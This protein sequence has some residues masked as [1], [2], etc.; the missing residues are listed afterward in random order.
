ME[1]SSNNIIKYIK[2][3]YIKIKSFHFNKKINEDFLFLTYIQNIA[4][5]VE[6]CYNNS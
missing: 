4:N 1:T 2:Y 5:F 3:K 6:Q